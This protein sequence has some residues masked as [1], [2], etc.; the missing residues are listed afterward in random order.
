[1]K[2]FLN[3]LSD[4]ER[5]SMLESILTEQY[6]QWEEWFKSSVYGPF[7]TRNQKLIIT[8]LAHR[9]MGKVSALLD[10]KLFIMEIMYTHIIHSLSKAET[11]E[12]YK[13]W[14]QLYVKETY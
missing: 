10:A 7:S 13:S 5:A 1:M 6:P 4:E 11:L 9:D 3:P 8:L 2:H 12:D 14:L